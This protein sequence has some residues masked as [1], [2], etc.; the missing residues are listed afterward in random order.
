MSTPD[1]IQLQTEFDALREGLR[2]YRLDY[3]WGAAGTYYR[4]A[5]GGS[6]DAT[7]RFEVLTGIAGRK[8]NELPDGTL[9]QEIL[10]APDPASQWY[11][12]LRH[13][14]GAFEFGFVGTQ[15]NDKGDDLGHI[16]TGKL[17]RPAD[18]SALVCLNFS[19]LPVETSSLDSN[20]TRT[21]WSRINSFLK[22]EAE[23]RGYLWLVIGF[24]IMAILTAMAL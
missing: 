13:H 10:E 16:Y 23:H 11:E 3:Q 2:F 6:N 7:R 14:S 22:K 17:N 15:T 24:I 4:L 18:S 5:G 9:S 1:W 8:L 21:T 20:S 19:S 12:T